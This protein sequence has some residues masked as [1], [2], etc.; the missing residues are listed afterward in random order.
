MG[1]R[2]VKALV[3]SYDGLPPS[4]PLDERAAQLT[5]GDLRLLL[6][7]ANALLEEAR[8]PRLWMTLLNY[9]AS[10]SAARRD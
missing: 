7:C 2:E 4:M 8:G 5:I 1:L 10:D 6:E 9:A 3:D